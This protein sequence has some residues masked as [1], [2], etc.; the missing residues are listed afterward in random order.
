MSLILASG[1]PYRQRLLAR[2]GQP[3]EVV[4]PEVDETPLDGE[5]PEALAR[6]LA[7]AKA[8]AIARARPDAIVI[9]SDQ[10]ASLDGRILGKPGTTSA[11][12][13]QLRACS[14]RSVR[15]YTGLALIVP[16]DPEPRVHLEP[17]EVHF[18]ALGESEIRDY[19]DRDQPLDC[20]GSFKWEALGIALFERMA[21]DDPTSLEGL[22]LIALTRM[23]GDAGYPVLGSSQHNT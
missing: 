13:A 7:I 22:P 10:V 21:G 9:G 2:L 5:Q 14:A 18:R 12:V 17:Y 15:F 3:F 19:V 20:A 16:Q 11:A 1:S 8:T 23:L 6:R 4:S